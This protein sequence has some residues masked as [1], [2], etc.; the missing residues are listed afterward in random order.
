MKSVPYIGAVTFGLCLYAV[1]GFTQGSLT[2]TGAPGPSMKTLSQVEPR[3]P[4]TSAPFI[5]NQPG[6][7]YLT[8][9]LT[10]ATGNGIEI[11]TNN[12]TVDLMGY[13][14]TGS[15]SMGT[16]ILIADSG[17]AALRRIV[18][19][20]GIVR[21]F[22]YGIN[23]FRCDDVQIE[24][25]MTCSNAEGGIDIEA[26]CNG[27][28]VRGCMITDNGNQGLLIN[29]SYAPHSYGNTVRDCVIRGNL[30]NGIKLAC[31]YG[32]CTAT[33]IVDCAIVGN[34]EG[35]LLSGTY[36]LC[37][38]TIVS[39]CLI[40]SNGDVGLSIDGSSGKCDGTMVYDC[41]ISDN[42]SYGLKMDGFQGECNGNTVRDCSLIGNSQYGISLSG[43]AGGCDGNSVEHCVL[44]KNGAIGISLSYAGGNRIVN[45]HVSGTTGASSFGIYSTSTT[46]NLVL[47]N[48]C[49]GQVSNFQVVPADT[50]GPVVTSSGILSTTNGAAALSP[51]AN[52]SR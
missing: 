4:V 38:A 40:S 9:N 29:G 7:Y 24:S 23:C 52:F 15:G 49:V 22:F 39:G 1:T 13:S 3:I 12:V 16:G 20:N 11:R 34:G 28:S 35:I 2:P 48:T 45:N 50:L 42:A 21:G 5:I 32:Q 26:G 36:G 30:N 14:I 10:Y 6:S 33:K 41:I 19:R 8:T 25:M 17:S 31:Q 47:Q 44:R 51:W 27:N 18:V 43:Q 46:N 37:D